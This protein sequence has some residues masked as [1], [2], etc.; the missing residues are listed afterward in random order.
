MH[1][2][3]LHFPSRAIV[4]TSLNVK[5]PPLYIRSTSTLEEKQCNAMFAPIISS[6][7]IL[8]SGL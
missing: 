8:M 3:I 1:D 4:D 5:N 7:S 2:T 6:V